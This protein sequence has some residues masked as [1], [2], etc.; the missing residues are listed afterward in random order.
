MQK[1]VWL[2]MRSWIKFFLG[3]LTALLLVTFFTVFF[4]FGVDIYVPPEVHSPVYLSG[5]TL[6]RAIDATLEENQG[7]VLEDGRIACMGN[8]CQPPTG[9]QRI[10]ATGLTIMPGMIELHGHFAAVTADNAGLSLT[11]LGWNMVRMRPDVRRRLHESGITAFRSVG[12]PLDYILELKQR[13]AAGEIAGP[14]MFVAGP[15]FTAPGGYPVDG[16]KNP[17]SS[18]FG[19]E[20]V[21][22]SDNPERIRQEVAMLAEHGADGIKAVYQGTGPAGDQ[23]PTLGEASLQALVAEAH[24]HG[25]WVAVHTG[26]AAELL[27]ALRAG[28]DTIEHGVRWGNSV[29]EEALHML[30]DQQV[31]YVPTLVHEPTAGMNIPAL[32][33]AGVLF[34]VGTDTNSPGMRYGDSYQQ[35]LQAMVNAGLPAVD[36]MLAATRNGA[37]AL[38]LADELGT[39]EVGKLADIVLVAGK[40]WEDIGEL[41]NIRMVI[42]GGDV[43]AV[44]PTDDRNL[45]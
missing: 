22:Q 30:V 23:L 42:Q 43:L 29:S 4:M 13:V 12:D 21:F 19:G 2:V 38:G 5:G 15:I 26:P 6:F 1:A 9:A 45:E 40:P 36:V 44:Q 10:D 39:L 25:M 16:G 33:N 3:V 7:M 35:E 11:R 37:E 20:M 14:R 17:N 34:G 32:Y 18:G 27:V 31:I 8:T 24:Q 41:R 28:A